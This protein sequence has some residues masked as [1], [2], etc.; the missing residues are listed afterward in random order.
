MRPSGLLHR[1]PRPPASD[2]RRGRRRLGLRSRITLSFAFGAFVISSALASVTFVTVRSQIV[3][4]EQ[5]SIVNQVYANA[6]VVQE[7]LRDPKNT[8]IDTLAQIDENANL[9]VMRTK[10]GHRSE[11]FLDVR[12]GWIEASSA[13][14]KQDLPQSLVDIV[15]SG[16]PAFQIFEFRGTPYLAVGVPIAS[17]SALFFQMFP[18]DQTA[19]TLRIIL[20]TLVAAGVITTLAGAVLGRW[21]A[22]RALRPLHDVSQA[23]LAIASGRLSTRLETADVRDLAVLA[24]SFNRM[25][26]RLQQR[27]ER[28]ARFTSDVSHE[29]R[30][31]LT[32]LAA[33]LSVIETRRSELPERSQRALDLVSAEIRRFQRMVGELLEI[34]RFDAGSADFEA[35]IVGVGELVRRA[36]DAAGGQAVP[37][38]VDPAVGRRKVVVDKRRIERVMTNLVENAQRYGGG[39]TRV[40]VEGRDATVRVAV[41]DHGPGVPPAERERV[42]ERFARGSV[43]AGT[44]GAGGGTGLG[45]A[46]VAEHVKLHNGRVWVEDAPGGGARFVVELPL[47]KEADLDEDDEVRATEEE[48][49]LPAAAGEATA[50]LPGAGGGGRTS[51]GASGGGPSGTGRDTGAGDGRLGNGHGARVAEVA[52][53]GPPPDDDAPA[54]TSAGAPGTARP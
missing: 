35:S 22:G 26:D 34:S 50:A 17:A 10:S 18:L 36:V 12:G 30:S 37:I 15:Q 45:L 31:P 47:S 51:D 32:T 42:F 19:Q 1:R 33:S 23:A 5:H 7:K 4:Q 29:L 48:A 49:R 21:A 52:P 40:T 24:S 53:P 38:E 11:S 44:R 43:A 27:I 3:G 14:N 9:S 16:Q 46:L 20:L 54:G 13:A 6:A 8:L 28:D 41:E 39:A 25:V 2:G